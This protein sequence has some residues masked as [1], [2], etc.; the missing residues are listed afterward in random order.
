M[1]VKAVL[2]KKGKPE[3][4]NIDVTEEKY[5]LVKNRLILEN[6]KIVNILKRMKTDGII[7][8]I[9]MPSNKKIQ[10]ELNE[11]IEAKKIIKDSIKKITSF[12]G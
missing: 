12:F 1:I 10:K 9:Y 2:I 3:Y 11:Y 8:S 7:K 6:K 4:F 5:F